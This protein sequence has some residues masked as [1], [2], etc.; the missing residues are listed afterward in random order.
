[1][2][3]EPLVY[4]DDGGRVVSR[5]AVLRSLNVYS[6]SKIS[7]LGRRSPFFDFGELPC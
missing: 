7:D 2:G 5:A 1:M 3:M 6:T 4:Q